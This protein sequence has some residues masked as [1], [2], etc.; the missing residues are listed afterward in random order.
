MKLW[1]PVLALAG[2]FGS[3]PLPAQTFHGYTCTED[4]SGHEAGYEWAERRGI[5]DPDDCGGRSES[6]IE[7]CKAYAEEYQD[8]EAGADWGDDED[9]DGYGDESGGD[10]WDDDSEDDWR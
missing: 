4:C 6:F 9:T 7:G 5:T 2:L 3:P 1:I 10:D 8:S